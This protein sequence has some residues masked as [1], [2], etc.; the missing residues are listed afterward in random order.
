MIGTSALIS[1]LTKYTI[2]EMHTTFVVMMFNEVYTYVVCKKALQSTLASSC[3]LLKV[4]LACELAGKSNLTV[5]L[6][7]ITCGVLP[8]RWMCGGPKWS[9]C[10]IEVRL[11]CD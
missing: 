2:M 11:V 3:C 4:Q 7:F 6:P 1:Y 10:I 8:V 5:T 9:I